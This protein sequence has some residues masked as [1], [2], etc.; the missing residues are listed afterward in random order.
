LRIAIGNTS[1][2]SQSITLSQ[3]QLEVGDT[4]TPFEHRS[5]GD[6]LARCQRYFEKDFSQ[7]TTPAAGLALP[8]RKTGIAFA[9]NN[10]GVTIE[11]AVTKRTSPTV[12]VY[13]GNN[14]GSSASGTVNRY[15]GSVWLE[16][17]ASGGGRLTDRYCNRDFVDSGLTT[18]YAYILQYSFTADAEL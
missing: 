1:A 7:G 9:T 10:F 12:V 11:F 17:S 4:A 16:K 5:Y 6:E 15:T 13:R 14:A 8:D 2:A 18:G 3:V